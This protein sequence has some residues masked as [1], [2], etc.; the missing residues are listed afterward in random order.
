MDT[1]NGENKVEALSRSVSVESESVESS[2]SESSER[3]AK[4]AVK[5]SVIKGPKG[6]NG[7]IV[8]Q[9]IDPV[10]KT[11]NDNIKKL[12]D[13]SRYYCRHRVMGH[14]VGKIKKKH[15]QS[16]YVC[17]ILIVE[18]IK[19]IDNKCVIS[20][21]ILMNFYDLVNY[22]IAFSRK[23]CYSQNKRQ[24]I[25]ITQKIFEYQLPSLKLLKKIIKYNEYDVCYNSLL[26]NT[27]FAPFANEFFNLVITNRLND[28]EGGPE[29]DILCNLVLNNINYTPQNLLNLCDC[30]NCIITTKV[31][32][33]IDSLDN[34]E[35]NNMIL[36]KE[37]FMK[38]ACKNLPWAMNIITSLTN[39]NCQISSDNFGIACN[40]GNFENLKMILEISRIPV[41][42]DHFKIVLK[43]ITGSQKRVVEEESDSEGDPLFSNKEE[44]LKK[45]ELLFQ[46]GFVPNRE[47]IKES[48]KCHVQIPNIERFE[49]II[50]D[51]EMHKCCIKNKFFPKYKF[52]CVSTE[53]ILLQEACHKKDG[54]IIKKLVKM[55]KLVPDEICMELISKH[56]ESTI[57]PFLIKSGGKVNLQCLRNISDSYNNNKFIIQ[58]MTEFEK[59]YMKEITGYKNKITEL[60]R[61]LKENINGDGDVSEPYLPQPII[62]NDLE[63]KYNVLQLNVDNDK[64]LQYR[65]K[66]KNKKVPHKKIVSFYGI[67]DKQKVSYA[68]FKKLLFEK[69]QNESWTCTHDKTLIKVPSQYRELFGL[70]NNENDV[71][72]FGDIEKLICMF[73]VNSC[74][75]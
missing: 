12:L 30:S 48:I 25:N 73:Y 38:T 10:S 35:I 19:M 57:F 6:K 37:N 54:S 20:E 63:I 75:L 65:Q 9:N 31:A 28:T 17:D 50:L 72:S 33:K 74:E 3:P 18:L 60:E 29:D 68:D 59:E 36:D 66:Y 22:G 11:Y 26:L 2:S 42:N 56:R 62:N 43:T 49:N 15:P 23:G 71:V 67:E 58:Y 61:Q 13:E 7:L 16:P 24:I 45:I 21:D 51:D 70:E 32:E 53:M 44:Q 46:N 39:K 55:H 64:I 4:R 5:R 8:E 52:N 69:I 14:Q 40:H 1:L 34:D 41:T 27:N 47:D